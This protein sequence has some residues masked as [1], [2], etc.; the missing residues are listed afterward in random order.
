MYKLL[1]D[2]TRCFNI[3]NIREFANSEKWTNES[4]PVIRTKPGP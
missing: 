3:A 2:Q 4:N 1:F